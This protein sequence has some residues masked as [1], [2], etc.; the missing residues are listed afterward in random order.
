MSVE[1]PYKL[2]Y[3]EPTEQNLT[4]DDCI[5]NTFTW[6]APKENWKGRIIFIHGYRDLMEVYYEFAEKLLE[7]G[8]DFFYF[9]QRGE[10]QTKLVND[11]IIG[12]NDDFHVYKSVDDMINYNLNDLI[13]KK[14][15][16]NEIH[17]MGLSM[18][19]GIV[20]NYV[21][22]GKLKDKLK[23]CTAICPLITLHDDTYPGFLIE[24]IVRSIAFFS[25]GKKLRV[26]SPLNLDYIVADPKYREFLGSKVDTKGLDGAFVETRDFILRGRSLLKYNNYSKIDKKLPL[27]ICHGDDDHINHVESSKKFINLLNEIDGMQ[28]KNIITYPN[29]RHNILID[30]P[31]IRSKVMSD[32]ISFLDANP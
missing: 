12:I 9:Y 4:F 26:K 15:H 23:S 29:G 11:S 7:N 25:F 2:K 24:I 22:N 6:Y 30:V 18:G 3:P 20:L 19:G 31:E 14:L 21:C 5:F 1:L 10:G 27:L 8:Y 16:I 32:I 13:E 17:L 28:N